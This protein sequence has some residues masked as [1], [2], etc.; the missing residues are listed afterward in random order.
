M[1]RALKTEIDREMI[2]AYIKRIDISKLHIVEITQKKLNRSISQ[3]SLYWLYL[4]C[5]SFETGNDR[6]EL[7]DIFKK[8][9]TEPK[10]VVLFGEEIDRYSTADLNTTQFKYYLDRI[11]VFAST[12]L[13][14]TLPDPEDR[15]WNEFYNFYIDK[16]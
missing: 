12:E 10:K 16:L 8:K 6:D 11:Q 4:T 1:K 3:N 2:I 5:I 13:S 15:Y 7:H 9:W 14:I